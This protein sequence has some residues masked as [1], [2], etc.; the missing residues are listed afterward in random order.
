MALAAY[1]H[2]LRAARLAFEGDQRVLSAARH[3]ARARFETGRSLSSDSD[4]AKH[5]IGHAE[6][7]ARILT[8][9]L[10]QGRQ[11]QVGTQAYKLRIHELTER[12]D[13]DLTLKALEK[14]ASTE[15]CWSQ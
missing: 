12:G 13:N 7:V 8:H 10:V 4:E 2:V 9:N 11:A 1:R 3:E 5:H 6:E 15:G 14:A